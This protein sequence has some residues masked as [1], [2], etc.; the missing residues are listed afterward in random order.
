MTVTVEQFEDA[1]E[2]AAAAMLTDDWD[3]ARKQAMSALTLAIA[4]PDG[5][6]ADSTVKYRTEQAHQLITEIRH[7]IWYEF[8]TNSL[9][10]IGGEDC[11]V[12]SEGDRGQR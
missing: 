1:I 7:R 5:S 3:T 4:I 12:S 8:W 10:Q 6:E 9:V 2:A 11:R